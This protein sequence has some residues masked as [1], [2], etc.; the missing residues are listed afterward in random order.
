M[1]LFVIKDITHSGN[2]LFYLNDDGYLYAIIPDFTRIYC[3][4]PIANSDYSNL[5]EEL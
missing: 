2:I 3:W 5:V 4:G 1:K